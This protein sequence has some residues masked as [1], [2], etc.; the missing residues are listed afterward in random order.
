[1]GI[2]KEFKEFA[3]KGNLVDIAI[4]LIIGAAFGKV[5]SSLVDNI[6]MPPLGVLIGGVDF[7]DLS[8]PL[9]AATTENG[10]EVPAVILKYGQFIQDVIDFLIIAL[11]VFSVVK[12]M[13]TIRKKEQEQ[14]VSP[15]PDVLT[16]DQILLT[17]IRDSL[18]N[19]A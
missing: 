4:G 10:K 17:E 2:I 14:P 19:K 13:N 8:I 3:I 6:I 5:V 18:K 9:R 16:K 15:A 11:A 1:M 7:S 12:L